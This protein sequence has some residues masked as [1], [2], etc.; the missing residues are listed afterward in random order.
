MKRVILTGFCL[1]FLTAC[2]EPPQSSQHQIYVFGTLVDIMLYGVSEERQQKAVSRISEDFQRMHHEWHA[3]K[4][5]PLVQIN[6]ALAQGQ[7]VRVIPSLIPIIK[8]S[9]ILS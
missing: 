5:G 7:S 6:R 9:S 8:Q 3:W 1:L 2:N 4:P